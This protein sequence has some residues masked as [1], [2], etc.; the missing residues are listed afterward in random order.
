M[1]D[2]ILVTGATGTQGNAVARALL[3]R[4]HPVRALSRDPASPAPAT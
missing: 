4:G 3:A 2:P 1:A